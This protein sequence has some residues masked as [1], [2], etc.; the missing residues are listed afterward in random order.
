[1]FVQVL[2]EKMGLPSG[3]NGSISESAELLSMLKYLKVMF[4]TSISDIFY[5]CIL[6]IYYCAYF[7]KD[8]VNGGMGLHTGWQ[9]WSLIVPGNLWELL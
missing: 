6:N 2:V 7:Y 1:M 8:A 5:A 4:Y 3:V 9:L